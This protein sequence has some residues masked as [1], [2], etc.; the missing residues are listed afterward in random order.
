M[1]NK[2][3]YFDIGESVSFPI[4]ALKEYPKKNVFVVGESIY[5]VYKLY[6][7]IVIKRVITEETV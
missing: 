2:P 7:R 3:Y 1:K 5:Y 6:D 4:D